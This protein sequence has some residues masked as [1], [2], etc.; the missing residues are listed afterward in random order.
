LAAQE[1]PAVPE[2]QDVIVLCDGRPILIRVRVKLDGK[3]L[4]EKWRDYMVQ[5][6]ADLDR[7]FDGVLNKS[8]A[9][10]APSL[11][12]S[13]VNF[14]INPNAASPA[15]LLRVA[16]AAGNV[17][18]EAFIAFYEKSNAAPFTTRAGQGRSQLGTAVLTQ[19]DTDGDRKLSAQEL[20]AAET[21]LRKRDYD[22]DE[23]VTDL[24]LVPG[25]NQF[26]G[27]VFVDG[28]GASQG[29]STLIHVVQAGTAQTAVA[30]ALLGRYDANKDGRLT[31][32]EASAELR[33][34]AA[35]LL[36]LDRDGDG[37]L[38]RDEIARF[39]DRRPDIE[40]N[41][42]AGPG[43]ASVPLHATVSPDGTPLG[44]YPVK[45]LADGNFVLDAGDVQLEFRRSGSQSGTAIRQIA[46]AQFAAY[47]ADKNDYIDETEARRIPFLAAAFKA[48]DR[49]G[50]GKVFKEEFDAYNQ[51]QND[52]AATRVVLEVTDDG[53]QLFELLDGNRD[54]RLSL[55]ELRTAP[56][57][58]NGRDSNQDG[59]LSGQ[60]I[61]R[62]LRL[63]LS[64]GSAANQFG[65]QVVFAGGGVQ[66]TVRPG[67]TETGPTWFRRMDRN[68]DGDLSP[69]EFL[70]PRD[71]F[72][73]IDANHDGLIDAKEAEAAAKN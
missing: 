24:E 51:R 2:A 25:Q 17:S 57:A 70:G 44:T 47:D 33:L 7:D 64:R 59:S 52:A 62:R 4:H 46:Q 8:E 63:D 26:G 18:R 50:D 16:D 72:D 73:R 3:P 68:H 23:I 30:D 13:L 34:P 42:A 21:T 12:G 31:V 55:R 15:P 29:A 1:R 60:E 53:Q 69:R 9:E 10:R 41:Y 28:Y 20:K 19:V 11:D 43:T 49:D 14:R 32:A 61:P 67:S 6:F 48:I 56:D 39:A 40:I 27:G 71:D 65:R 45:M 37:S 35:L 58:L 22:D 5:V 66:R 54:G 38:S 36:D